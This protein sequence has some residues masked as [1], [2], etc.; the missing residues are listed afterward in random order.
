MFGDMCRRCV[1]PS[2]AAYIYIGSS[3]PSASG[4]TS[5]LPGAEE[6]IKMAAHDVNAIT[7]VEANRRALRASR[8]R[9]RALTT[10]H[11]RI[12]AGTLHMQITK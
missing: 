4:A 8:E 12:T 9:Q 5:S 7:A 3:D 10:E 6:A 1:R 11:V 2:N